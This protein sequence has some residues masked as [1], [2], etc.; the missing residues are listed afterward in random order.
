M[1]MSNSS[2]TTSCILHL[3]MRGLT[4]KHFDEQVSGS[5]SLSLSLSLTHSL[6]FMIRFN[7]QNNVYLSLIRSLDFMIRIY[8]LE[9]LK[10]FLRHCLVGQVSWDTMIFPIEEIVGGSSARILCVPRV[11][12]SPDTFFS[13]TQMS[14]NSEGWAS[15][16]SETTVSKL[17]S[18]ELGY[19]FKCSSSKA[20][21][22]GKYQRS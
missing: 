3:T 6:D 15:T 13:K 16:Q 11:C 2:M 22:V 7:V 17:F 21:F 14:K 1:I 4:C 12:S 20:A 19:G 5:L 8:G 9:V 10:L 18:L